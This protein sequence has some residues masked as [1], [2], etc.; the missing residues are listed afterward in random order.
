[1][2]VWRGSDDMRKKITIILGSPRRNGNSETL[3]VSLAKGAS[4]NGYISIATR[5]NGLKINGCM[6]CRRCW[7]NGSHCFVNDDMKEIYA[8]IDKSDVMVF[9]TPLYFYSWS[10]QIKSVWDRL[11]PYFSPNSK[12]NVKARRVV[13]IASAG[14]NDESCFDGLK[15]SFELA[16]AYAK[17]NIAGELLVPG[18]HEADAVSGN[19]GLLGRAFE[20]GKS[21]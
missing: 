4:E 19:E 17:W 8:A 13:L 20:L 3:A 7:S 15:K 2:T 5:I 21:L 12:I 14:D 16:C 9:A 10:S 1:M 18:V 6:G 11:L